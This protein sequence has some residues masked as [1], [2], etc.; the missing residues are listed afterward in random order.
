[1]WHFDQQIRFLFLTVNLQEWELNELYAYKQ[2][3]AI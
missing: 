2:S 3:K 1:M